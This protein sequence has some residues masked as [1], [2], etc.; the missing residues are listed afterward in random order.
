MAVQLVKQHLKLH[1]LWSART[2]VMLQ[3]VWAVLIIA[4]ILQ[5]LRFEIAQRVGR[6][7]FDISMPLVAEYFPRWAAAGRDPMQMMLERGEAMRLIR[8][9]RLTVYEV[10]EIDPELL[11]PPPLDLVLHR[12]PRYAQRKCRKGNNKLEQ[13]AQGP[14]LPGISG[15][16]CPATVI[17]TEV[18]RPGSPLN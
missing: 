9:S 2:T 16:T 6:D 17:S 4:Q 11:V 12:T 5:A 7:P 8:L 13:V 3:Q 1:L 15:T 14:P 18:R 10:P